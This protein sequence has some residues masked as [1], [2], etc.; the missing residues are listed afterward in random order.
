MPL[1]PQHL[2]TCAERRCTMDLDFIKHHEKQEEIY[3]QL[4][5]S[6][7]NKRNP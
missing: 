2:N 5:F 7:K 6:I 3:C 1:I 4:L